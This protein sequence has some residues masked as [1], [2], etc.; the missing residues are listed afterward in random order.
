LDITVGFFYREF[1]EWLTLDVDYRQFLHLGTIVESRIFASRRMLKVENAKRW[2]KLL[3]NMCLVYTHPER[4]P[5][6]SNG[7]GEWV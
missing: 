3:Q 7:V 6:S 5:P 4:N 2:Q 1:G